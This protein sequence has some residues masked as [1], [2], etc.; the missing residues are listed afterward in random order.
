MRSKERKH[1]NSN[2]MSRFDSPQTTETSH[3]TSPSG[4]G[5]DVLL[6]WGHRKRSRVS[7]A[8]IED[9]SSSVHAKQRKVVPPAAP[10]AAKFP[11]ASMPP[12]PPL[13]SS[14]A[15]NGRG[16]KDSPR[17]LIYQHFHRHF[18]FLNRLNYLFIYNK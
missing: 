7:R 4:S 2:N 10:Q 6:K 13:V 16:R 8:A 1:N 12:P 11:S 15:S 14:A 9:S 18:T 5:G 17:Y 3:S